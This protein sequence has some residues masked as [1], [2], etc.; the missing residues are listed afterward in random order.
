MAGERIACA[1]GLLLFAACGGGEDDGAPDKKDASS[2]TGVGGVGGGAKDGSVGGSGGAS[3]SG[4][5]GGGIA[6]ASGT[7]GGDAGNVET[8][9]EG[10]SYIGRF[11][12]GGATL[13]WTRSDGAGKNP[14]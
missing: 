12:V 7:G 4:G 9:L 2:E 3:A 1:L 13:F 8:L 10:Q 5:S 14:E 6:G 11:L